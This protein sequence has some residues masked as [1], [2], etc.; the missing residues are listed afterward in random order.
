MSLQYCNP[1]NSIVGT[2][3]YCGWWVSSNWAVAILSSTYQFS[4]PAF[5]AVIWQA[6]KAIWR[7]M[8]PPFG[9]C[10]QAAIC[11]DSYLRHP[12]NQSMIGRGTSKHYRS[13]RGKGAKSDGQ[14]DKGWVFVTH[15]FVNTL[16]WL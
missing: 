6:L 1:P 10:H 13:I 15:S 5:R 2:V 14:I 4:S 11:I 8:P 9:E 7:N 3:N 16:L 12:V